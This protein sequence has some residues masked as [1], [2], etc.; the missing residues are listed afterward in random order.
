MVR[1]D[2]KETELRQLYKKHISDTEEFH[3]ELLSS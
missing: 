3:N 2:Q 1:F